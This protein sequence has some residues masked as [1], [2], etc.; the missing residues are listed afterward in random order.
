MGLKV[1]PVTTPARLVLMMP[2]SPTRPRR[3]RRRRRRVT[4]ARLPDPSPDR[5]RF[6]VPP[7]DGMER[8][9]DGA[10]LG[11]R[12]REGVRDRVRGVQV[13]EARE[14][15]RGRE[16]RTGAVAMTGRGGRV[17]PSRRGRRR[18]RVRLRR[19]EV[20]QRGRF[21]RQQGSRCWRRTG[22]GGERFACEVSQDAVVALILSLY[23]FRLGVARVERRAGGRRS[24]WRAAELDAAEGGC[25]GVPLPWRDGGGLYVDCCCR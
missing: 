21:F 23:E 2:V 16:P 20:W 25:E 17:T 12:G 13:H 3:R 14:A 24:G 1:S 4:A 22:F 5:V 18:V 15:P 9:H 8:V 10:R 6:A 11:G 19:G 7:K